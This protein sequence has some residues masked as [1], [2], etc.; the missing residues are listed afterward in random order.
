MIIMI[1]LIILII[2]LIML[3]IIIIII[4]TTLILTL[5]IF[6]RAL[7]NIVHRG[8]VYFLTKEEKINF[9]S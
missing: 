2:L 7:P 5:E 6:K 8:L 4:M 3:I 1:I 9:T